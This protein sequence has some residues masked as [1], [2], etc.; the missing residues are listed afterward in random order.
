MTLEVIDKGSA[1][2]AHPT[3]LLFVHGAWHAAW[4]W[5]QGFL[6]FFADKGFRAIALSLR[7]HGDSS[8]PEPL[9]FLSIAHYVQDVATI[10]KDLP[11]PPVVIGHSMGGF[12]VQKYLEKHPAPAG[13]L[14]ASIP[15][16]GL[17]PFLLRW[18]R[19]QPWRMARALL[20]G[21]SVQVFDSP[22]RIREKFY[23]PHTPDA[24]VVRFGAL[25][26]NERWRVPADTALFKLPRP[27][28]VSTPLLVLGAAHDGCFTV[29]EAQSTARA[30]RTQA[31][32]FPDMGHNMMLEPGWL[33]VA[34]RINSWLADR[35]I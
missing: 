19:L 8:G 24:D 9:Q 28:R 12:V 33:G 26:Q 35:G 5:D 22:R 25:L 27:K 13:V 17:V 18:T 15:S 31:E 29:K 10:A 34:E 30:Y 2:P 7:G 6:D 11:T 1:T 3:P 16:R 4:C 21:N 32:V 23:S 14:V 20:T